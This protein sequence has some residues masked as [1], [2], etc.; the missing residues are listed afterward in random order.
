MTQMTFDISSGSEGVGGKIE[1]TIQVYVLIHAI[2]FAAMSRTQIFHASTPIII[3]MTGATNQLAT[4]S[5]VARLKTKEVRP[6]RHLGTGGFCRVHE[7]RAI[8]LDNDTVDLY[9]RDER[10]NRDYLKLRSRTLRGD[11]RFVIKTIKPERMEICQKYKSAIQDLEMEAF[12]LARVRHPNIIQLRGIGQDGHF[13]ILDRLNETLK[14]RMEAWKRELKGLTRPTLWGVGLS[15]KDRIEKR[16]QQLFLERLNVALD[17]ASAL[18]YLHENRIIYRDLKSTNCGFDTENTCKLFDFGLARPLP[19]DSMED[20]YK[21]SGKAGTTRCMSPEVYKC[22]PYSLKAD[23][24]SYAHLLWEILSLQTPY[25]NYT[26][27]DYKLRVVKNGIRPTIDSSW[28]RELQDL[29]TK[30]WHADM[31]ERPT[32]KQVSEI[33]KEMI[34][35]EEAT[36]SCHHQHQKLH[37]VLPLPTPRGFTQLPSSS[38][39]SSTRPSL[40]KFHSAPRLC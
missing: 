12:L 28:P 20:T 26:R 3:I 11:R 29:L 34:A 40:F 14:D 13:L 9:S 37:A 38:T 33:L 23:V 18:E 4:P 36:H 10:L 6:G 7:V 39:S 5:P 21:M 15:N 19:G 31:D 17:I 22:Q 25:E 35:N 16:K 1:I 27:K 8:C 32:M 24:Y 30:A 2:N